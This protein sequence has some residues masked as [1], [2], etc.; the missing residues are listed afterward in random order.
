GF[1][2]H[3]F[4]PVLE[5]VKAIVLNS[6]GR[7]RLVQLIEEVHIVARCSVYAEQ[8]S[9]ALDGHGVYRLP[10]IQEVLRNELRESDSR[11]S[12]LRSPARLL[13]PPRGDVASKLCALEVDLLHGFVDALTGF[14]EA[15]GRGR[16][17]E[18]AAAG[19]DGAT[20]LAS[21]TGVE[22]VDVW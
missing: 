5:D 22:H 1:L 14:A 8:K 12:L 13:P 10:E 2:C 20:V 16:D 19:S 18:D 15:R 7:E 3:A 4:C 9:P 6:S 17:A 21:G 11:S